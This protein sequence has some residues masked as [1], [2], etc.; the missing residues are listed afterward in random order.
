MNNIVIIFLILSGCDI[1]RSDIHDYEQRRSIKDTI[2]LTNAVEFEK[3][4]AN[5]DRIIVLQQTKPYFFNLEG[6]KCVLFYWK[7]T[8]RK[9]VVCY[10][11]EDGKLADHYFS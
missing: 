7:R 6:R 9:S 5:V 8:D 2:F 3:K 10:S 1:F 11:T 4:R